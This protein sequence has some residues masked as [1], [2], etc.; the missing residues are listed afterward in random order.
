MEVDLYAVIATEDDEFRKPGVKMW[1]LFV[2][3]N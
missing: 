3:Q 1:E 2:Q